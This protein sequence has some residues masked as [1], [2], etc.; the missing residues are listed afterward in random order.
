MISSKKDICWRSYW[1]KEQ[2]SFKFSRNTVTDNLTS[3]QTFVTDSVEEE[4]YPFGSHGWEGTHKVILLPPAAFACCIPKMVE[5]WKII[6]R[7]TQSSD[8]RGDCVLLVVQKLKFIV[9][10]TWMRI[11]LNQCTLAVLFCLINPT[12]QTQYPITTLKLESDCRSKIPLKVKC[13]GISGWLHIF[14][15]RLVST[16][17]RR[18]S[19]WT[20]I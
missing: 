16:P 8:V 13:L 1:I 3:Y 9:Y 15:K 18:N 10:L 5:I 12:Q 19:H 6:S 4:E 11:A 14:A 17:K 20:Y 2:H 7:S